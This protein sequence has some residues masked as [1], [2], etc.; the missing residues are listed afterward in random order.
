MWEVEDFSRSQPAYVYPTPDSAAE[1]N[2]GVVVYSR[3]FT[4]LAH[5]GDA[6]LRILDL[7]NSSLPPVTPSGAEGRVGSVAFSPDNMHL[8]GIVA[9]N[10]LMWDL[11]NP[12]E[13]P[14]S[15]GR[16]S[17]FAFSPDSLRIAAR[18]ASNVIHIW[19]L[20]KPDAPPTLLQGHKETN[21]PSLTFSPDNRWL[22]FSAGTVTQVWDLNRP[23]NPLVQFSVPNPLRFVTTSADGTRIAGLDQRNG[24]VAVWDIRHPDAPLAVFQPQFGGVLTL[25]FS[26]DGSRLAAGMGPGIEMWD[27]RNPSAPAV[28]LQAPNAMKLRGVLNFGALSFSSDGKRLTTGSRNGSVVVWRISSGASDYLCERVWRNLSIDEWSQ[29]LGEGIPYERTCPNLPSGVGAPGATN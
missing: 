13:P 20:R 25:S 22:V 7:H 17:V 16:F 6:G 2:P 8:A 5:I 18:D 10:L 19:N 1:L 29:Y 14:R 27:L 9:S 11:R 12:S 3:D 24:R 4:R 23:G 26:S 28:V 15:L 21:I